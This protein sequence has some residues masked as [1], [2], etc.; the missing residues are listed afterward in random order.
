MQ[1]QGGCRLKFLEGFQF[2]EVFLK[3]R[4]RRLMRAMV[5]KP[6]RE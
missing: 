5:E 4:P 1:V 2:L 6:W 3:N